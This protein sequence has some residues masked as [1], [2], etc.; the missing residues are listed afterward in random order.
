MMMYMEKSNPG[1]LTSARMALIMGILLPVLETIRRSNQILHLQYFFHWFDDYI[2]GA[3][4]IIAAIRV[5]RSKPN[6]SLFLLV[7]WAATAGVL[8]MSLLFQLNLYL[9]FG[10]EE[11]VISTHVVAFV[12]GLLVTYSLI[13]LSKSW[14]MVK[15]FGMR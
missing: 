5:L 8:V 12:K 6:A 14:R 11:G 2:L 7:A 3:L 10:K 13:G 1:L 4:L 9:G 15:T